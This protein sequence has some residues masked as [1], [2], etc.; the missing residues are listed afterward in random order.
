MLRAPSGAPWRALSAREALEPEGAGGGMDDEFEAMLLQIRPQDEPRLAQQEAFDPVEADGPHEMIFAASHMTRVEIGGAETIDRYLSC[1]ICLS[2][3]SQPTATECLHRFCSECIESALRLG[4]NKECPSCRLPIATRRALRRDDNFE[5]L[6]LSLYPDG[7]ASDDE[8]ID[9]SKFVFTP[10]PPPKEV[11]RRSPK[12]ALGAGKG[13]A[14]A[15]GARSAAAVAPLLPVPEPKWACPQCTLLNAGSARKCKVCDH[16]NPAKPQK[17]RRPA[18]QA[19]NEAPE[20]YPPVGGTSASSSPSALVA[21]RLAVSK[22]PRGQVARHLPPPPPPPLDPRLQTRPLAHVRDASSSAH[23]PARRRH[24]PPDARQRSWQVAHSPPSNHPQAEW[25]RQTQR[26]NKMEKDVSVLQSE[27]DD[28]GARHRSRDEADA[29][30]TMADLPL[31]AM[32]TPATPLDLSEAELSIEA[33]LLARGTFSL[34]IKSFQE[35]TIHV[36]WCF[37][38]ANPGDCNAWISLARSSRVAE[39]CARQKYKIITKNKVCG[40]VRFT[41]SDLRRLHSGEYG[42]SLHATVGGQECTL[43]VSRSFFLEDGEPSWTAVVASDEEDGLSADTARAD[44][45]G[46][47]GGVEG[48]AAA[49]TTAGA[50]ARGGR[51]R[52]RGRGIGGAASRGRVRQAEPSRPASPKVRWAPSIDEPTFE[53]AALLLLNALRRGALHSKAL[54]P[55]LADAF[56]PSDACAEL[57]LDLVVR[58]TLRLLVRAGFLSRERRRGSSMPLYTLSASAKEE[59]RECPIPRP[60]TPTLVT[61]PLA[62]PRPAGHDAADGRDDS[63]FDTAQEVRTPSR[64]CSRRRDPPCDARPPPART[65]ARAVSSCVPPRRTL[66]LGSCAARR[67]LSHRPRPQRSLLRTASRSEHVATVERLRT[68]HPQRRPKPPRPCRWRHRVQTHRRA[69]RDSF[70]SGSDA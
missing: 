56:Q 52:G 36:I 39:A 25:D 48:D 41:S 3:V 13:D 22:R 20:V 14:P 2:I 65:R 21:P 64:P 54:L 47:D 70:R 24:T 45:L 18:A 26:V 17:A 15:K 37:P 29:L 49:D 66:R 1:P 44:S 50:T 10:P 43:A 5:R 51:G 16:P 55:A 69:H 57:P 46:A 27:R 60:P 40:E 7:N 63:T 6:V 59:S 31:L 58:D 28:R 23:A 9:I 35:G 68:S 19:D 32:P 53:N 42:L 12:V 61:D 67:V 62:S 8:E 11:V 38:T 34:D 30:P 33:Q 4:K